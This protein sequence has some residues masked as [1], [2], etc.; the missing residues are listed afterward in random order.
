MKMQFILNEDDYIQLTDGVESIDI[1]IGNFIENNDYSRE[2]VSY[3]LNCIS[4]YNDNI[5][6]VIRK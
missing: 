2:S 6:R 1:V 3:L 5:H 4:E